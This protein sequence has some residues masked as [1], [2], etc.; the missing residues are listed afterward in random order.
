MPISSHMKLLFYR[1]KSNISS[2]NKSMNKKESALLLLQL[3][4]IFLT[5]N[6][7]CHKISNNFMK[8]NKKCKT[9]ISNAVRYNGKNKKRRKLQSLD[10][11]LKSPRLLTLLPPKN[12]V[13]ATSLLMSIIV[14]MS[15]GK[16]K[17]MIHNIILLKYIIQG[18]CL[19]CS[20]L[21]HLIIIIIIYFHLKFL[22]V[23]R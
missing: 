10:T 4:K 2:K 8:N 11:N 1:I 22:Y 6:L 23:L 5:T 14:F 16:I 7:I 15:L 21:N 18:I 17:W 19:T 9:F 3:I 20:I 12:T 13:R